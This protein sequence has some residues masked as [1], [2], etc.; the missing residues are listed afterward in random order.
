MVLI[1]Q[2]T[3]NNIHTCTRQ[4][5]G[6]KDTSND[7]DYRNAMRGQYNRITVTKGE[8]RKISLL[9]RVR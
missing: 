3:M 6:V 4:N 1:L 2:A 7:C 9:C 5:G 8:G